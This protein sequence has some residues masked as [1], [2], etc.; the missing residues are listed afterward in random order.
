MRRL[1]STFALLFIVS[2]IGRAQLTIKPERLPDA[3]VDSNYYLE[4]QPTGGTAPYRWNLRGSLP[5]GVAFD[6]PTGTLTGIPT[7]AGTY[8][9]TVSLSDAAHAVAREYVLRVGAGQAIAIVWTRAP[10]VENGAITGEVELSNTGREAFDLTFI[11]VAV[12]EIGRATALGYQ[13]F[14]LSPG[15]Q[16]IPFAANLP[17][18]TYVVHADAIGEI[19]R[20][21]TIRRARLQVQ[22]L[23]IP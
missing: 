14:S 1:V 12:N 13:H 20:T 10:A 19:A 15:K 18:G 23:V 5:D 22:P 8:R 16:R 3:A 21:G 4:L 11:A 7:R 9:F 2:G 6:A 17:R